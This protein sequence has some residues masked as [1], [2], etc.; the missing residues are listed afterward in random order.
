MLSIENTHPSWHA[1]LKKALAAMDQNYLQQLADNDQWLPGQAQIFSAFSLEK[2][3]VTFILFG[4]TPYP[5]LES[6]NGYAFW[7][8]NVHDIFSATGFSK[9]VNRATSL[10]NILKMLLRAKGHLQL[11]TSQAAIAAT[12]KSGLI[13]SLDE[14]FINMQKCGILLL[15][16]SLVL[17]DMNKNKEAKHWLPFIEIILQ[18]LSAQKPTLILF[19]KIAEKILQLKSAASFNYFSCEHPYNI[20]FIRNPKVINFFT[21]LH[22][23]AKSNP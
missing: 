14:L 10:R 8:A 6:A 1:T 12:D 22:L 11:D 9:P 13:S 3:N 15:N 19:G 5:R 7:D 20:S 4:E 18:D 2:N 16:A 17:S 23:L 21:P